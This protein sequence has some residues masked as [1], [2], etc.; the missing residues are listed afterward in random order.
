[1]P[2][3]TPAVR[4]V[5]VVKEFGTGDR[6]VRALDGIRLE[7]GRGECVAVVGRSGSGKSTLVNMLAG[8]DV[9][10]R[11][12][13]WI[14]DSELGRMS[15]AALTRLRRDRIG[16]VYQFFNLLPTLS[17]EE[18]VALPA[19]LQ[20]RQERE[21]RARAV[22]LLR[23]VG[24]EHRLHALPHTLS[25]GEMQRVG[26]ARSVMNEPTLILA[27]EPTGNLDSRSAGVVLELLLR[28]AATH[29]ATLV[30]V[31]HSNEVAAAGSRTVE[32]LDGRVLSDRPHPAQ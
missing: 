11:G 9:P 4:L 3:E 10:T 12:E 6:Q 25:G 20:G 21:V 22:E 5:D 31:T 29:R 13:V 30:M 15:D 1:M 26:I 32:L 28:V 17:A 24:L 2:D 16:V 19:L 18:N 27:D 14:G 8:I 23:E 7:I